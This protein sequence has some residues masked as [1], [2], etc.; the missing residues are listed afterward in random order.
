MKSLLLTSIHIIIFTTMGVNSIAQPM[1]HKKQQQDKKVSVKFI[2]GIEIKRNDPVQTTSEP[3]P[4]QQSPSSSPVPGNDIENSSSIQFKYAQV[5]NKDVE[6]VNNI[7]LFSFID[8]WWQTP[9]QYGGTTKSGIDCSAFSCT[10]YSNVF[11][12]ALP[13]SSKEQYSVCEKVDRDQLKEGDLVFFNTRGGVSHV[14]VYL[15]DG[16]F[17]HAS[18]SNGVVINNLNDDY[19]SARFLG[20]GRVRKEVKL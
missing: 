14:G 2:E 9:Y 6:S 17:V 16:Y 19:Y 7:A 15:A 13:R 10:L 20:G 5:L 1:R 11:H 3:V 4:L 8:N 12:E 18:T